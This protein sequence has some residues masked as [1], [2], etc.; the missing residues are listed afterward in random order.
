[1][2]R[3]ALSSADWIIFNGKE[4][5]LTFN[6]PLT[7][8]GDTVSIT[9]AGSGSDGYLSSTD[10][11]IFNN[12]QDALPPFTTGAVLFGDGTSIPAQDDASFYWNSLLNRLGLGTTTPL[13]T[14][15]IVGNIKITDGTQ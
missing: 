3:G 5:V 11:N 12:K 15:D 2:K 1:M 4:N 13:A 8:V 9:Q 10:W 7:R 6:A 14:L